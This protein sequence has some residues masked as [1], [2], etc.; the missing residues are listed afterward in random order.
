MLQ[1]VYG[2]NVTLCTYVSKVQRSSQGD[3]RW[4]HE[5][6]AFNKQDWNQHWM[7]KAG[8]VWQSLVDWLN[9]YKSVGQK[10][11]RMLF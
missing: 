10:K 11:K 7:S 8:G 2:D 3:E 4:F 9:G 1:N 5:Q 6:E